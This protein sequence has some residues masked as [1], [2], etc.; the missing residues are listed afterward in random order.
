MTLYYAASTSGF[1][2]PAINALIPEDA[3][4]ITSENHAALL[5][6]QGQGRVIQADA[7]G[8]PVAVDPPPLPA[9]IP[10]L[11]RLQFLIGLKEAGFIT[12]EEGLAATT[13]TPPANIAA[14]FDALP[15]AEKFRALVRFAAMTQVGRGEPLVA[16]YAAAQNLTDAQVDAFFISSAQ[17]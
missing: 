10:T 14:L 5:H 12:E 15:A 16:A 8:Y 17:L 6:A 9:A 3:K 11:T 2:D 13:G 7:N 1:Y 4:E